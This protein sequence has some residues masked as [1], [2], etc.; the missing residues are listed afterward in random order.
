MN[1]SCLCLVASSSGCSEEYSRSAGQLTLVATA[2]AFVLTNLV[3][4]VTP[5]TV[6]HTVAVNGLQLIQFVMSYIPAAF[7]PAFILGVILSL[8]AIY[9]IYRS[10]RDGPGK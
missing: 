9:C 1:N 4:T 5:G 3:L 8:Y 6:Q 7:V 2:S 10:I